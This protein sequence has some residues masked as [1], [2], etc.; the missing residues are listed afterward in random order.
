MGTCTC[1]QA[2]AYCQCRLSDTECVDT[3]GNGSSSK[4]YQAK[5]TLDPDPTN[6]LED[7]PI[8]LLAVLPRVISNPP[9]AGARYKSETS[10]ITTESQPIAGDVRTPIPL[11]FESWDTEAMHITAPK[12]KSTR[13]T[14]VSRGN[15]II[16]GHARWAASAKQT[17]RAVGIRLNGGRII[18][19]QQVAA[20]GS[21]VAHPL[22]ATT[23]YR[24]EVDDFLEL[25]V[26]HGD[27]LLPVGHPSASENNQVDNGTH[28]LQIFEQP[29]M[30]SCSL[31]AIQ[32]GTY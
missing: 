20:R 1:H 9:T 4:P 15:Y 8:G 6:I 14:V 31:T 30:H 16:S 25:I 23:F 13:F 12:V 29:D 24:L 10:E 5:F 19:W 22:T 3:Q 28:V 17:G 7:T 18:A 11:E 21:E 2:S 26:R 32:V 27:H